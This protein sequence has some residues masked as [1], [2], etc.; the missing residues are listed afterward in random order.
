MFL[1]F[2]GF[3]ASKCSYFVTT[4]HEKFLFVNGCEV[5]YTGFEEYKIMYTNWTSDNIRKD[6]FDGA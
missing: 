2:E 6:D 3:S 5:F 1:F 4:F